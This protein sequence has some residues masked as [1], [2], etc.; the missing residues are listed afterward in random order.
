MPGTIV[1]T[2]QGRRRL[3]RLP[4]ITVNATAN[5]YKAFTTPNPDYEA[6]IHNSSGNEVGTAT[7]AVSPLATPE[8]RR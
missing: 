8:T 7:Y 3:E 2:W 5:Y 1:G 6:V 4:R